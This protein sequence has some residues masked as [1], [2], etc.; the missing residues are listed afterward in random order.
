MSRK[1]DLEKS[2]RSIVLT[3]AS[4]IDPEQV[5]WLWRDEHRRVPCAEIV[6][7]AGHG[8]VGKS[9]EN[10]WL[11]AQL[12]R[13]TLPGRYHGRPRNCLIAATEDSWSRTVV[14]RL[15]A[16]GAD[17]TRVYRVEVQTAKFDGLAL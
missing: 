2:H 3:R 12:T 7:T 1:I 8:G 9:T 5:R 6:L 17:R 10:M 16:A 4:D 11:I 13:G 14:P 15:I